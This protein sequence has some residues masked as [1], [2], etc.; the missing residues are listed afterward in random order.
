MAG[1]YFDGGQMPHE[2]VHRLPE[3]LYVDVEKNIVYSCTD[4]ALR[5]QETGELFL[6]SRQ[7]EP[8]LGPWFV[9]G[10]DKYTTGTAANA[11]LQVKNDLGL[12]LPE[13]RFKF[14]SEYS[15][16]FPVASPGREEHGRHTKNAVMCI[17]LHPD[18]V[19]L[20]NDKV[21]SGQIRDEYSSGHW[22]Q[23]SEIANKD[24]DFPFALKQFVRDLYGHD[25]LMSA[26]YDE[27]L[28]ENAERKK[29]SVHAQLAEIEARSRVH[30]IK[31]VSRLGYDESTAAELETIGGANTMY[32]I[33]W[34]ASAR[35]QLEGAD[36]ATIF[37]DLANDDKIGDF[38][39]RR[40]LEAWGITPPEVMSDNG[41][42]LR[43]VLRIASA[44]IRADE[45][46]D[47]SVLSDLKQLQ[48]LG[49][50]GQSTDY[51]L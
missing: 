28:K 31:E 5:N 45:H 34:A 32:G 12:E 4:V 18:E 43:K 17:D 27:A 49:H 21:A 11:A 50:P 13:T 19:A 10:R 26:L 44:A 14:I 6:G 47:K 15:T 24:S 33:Y 40:G 42:M 23:P 46:L 3:E 30:R 41:P 1:E 25:L 8:Q 36:V 39:I 7:T 22:Y 9:G 48:N 16:S 38:Q 35:K 29:Q 37:E 2:P 51:Q 20:L